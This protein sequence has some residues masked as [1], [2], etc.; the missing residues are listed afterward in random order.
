MAVKTSLGP[1]SLQITSD[2]GSLRDLWEAL[3]AKAPCTSAQTFDWAQAW[4]KQVLVPE[5]RAPGIVVGLGKDGRPLFLW[6]FEMGTEYGFPVLKWLGQDH[7]N[8]NMGL[9]LSL[10][11]I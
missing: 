4:T 9:F 1:I 10:I 8:Y 6:P 3:Q 5:G 2:L 11:H 7:A